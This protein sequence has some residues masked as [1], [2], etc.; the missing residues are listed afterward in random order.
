MEESKP[1]QIDENFPPELLEFIG[2][3]KKKKVSDFYLLDW[4]LSKLLKKNEIISN[5]KPNELSALNVENDLSFQSLK[6]N[7]K[8]RSNIDELPSSITDSVSSTID[9]IEISL[10]PRRTDNNADYTYEVL[11]KRVFD[12]MREKYPNR[13]VELKKST[14][15]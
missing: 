7:K 15:D 11:L 4:S 2:Q 9:A 14:T 8:K 6:K 13:D 1:P 10:I 12:I 3:K 5:D